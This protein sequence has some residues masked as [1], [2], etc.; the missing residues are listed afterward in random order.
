MKTRFFIII[1]AIAIS[2]V[3]CQKNNGVDN[4]T[5]LTFLK[6]ELGGCN[7]KTS[8][9]N[10]DN[11]AKNDTVIISI[12]NDSID[13]FIGQNYICCAPFIT[14]CQIKQDSILMSIKDTCSK[15]NSCYCR[16]SCYYTFN[17]KFLQSDKN[18]YNYKI[19]L[20]DPREVGSKLIKTGIIKTK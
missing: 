12:I 5:K 19:L 3:F 11:I 14:D 20:S 10:I 17:F 13:I 9:Q 8:V 1:S 6:T 15:P 2:L 7:I 16:C 4:S 18:N